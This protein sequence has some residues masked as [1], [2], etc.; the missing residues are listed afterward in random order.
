MGKD[1][2]L[3]PP[4][5]E[6]WDHLSRRLCLALQL[7]HT[8]GD[9]PCSSTEV[10]AGSVPALLA[11]GRVDCSRLRSAEDID[12][13]PALPRRF[14]P[15]TAAEVAAGTVGAIT[16]ADLRREAEPDAPV[17]PLD[18]E[19]QRRALVRYPVTQRAQVNGARLGI[20]DL[21]LP[22]GLLTVL[23]DNP[24]E[25]VVMGLLMTRRMGLPASIVQAAAGIAVA[26]IFDAEA[27]QRA[28]NHPL[29]SRMR[30]LVTG[31][32]A[33]NHISYRSVFAMMLHGPP[34]SATCHM[35]GGV[36]TGG[37]LHLLSSQRR[38]TPQE[39]V[40]SRPEPD[41]AALKRGSVSASARGSAAAAARPAGSGAAA[42]ASCSPAAACAVPAAAGA[43]AGASA[44]P[45]AP[46]STFCGDVA[47]A[48]SMRPRA[49]P[50]FVFWLPIAGQAEADAVSEGVDFDALYHFTILR[51]S[52][53][54]ALRETQA[55]MNQAALRDSRMCAVIPV[56]MLPAAVQAGL[57][58][59]YSLRD[60]SWRLLQETEAPLPC[61]AAFLQGLHAVG[62]AQ[63]AGAPLPAFEVMPA[64]LPLDHMSL[65]RL[66]TTQIVSG[67]ATRATGAGVSVG[68]ALGRTTA[69]FHPAASSPAWPADAAAALLAG[70]SQLT[71]ITRDSGRIQLR[72]GP[73]HWLLCRPSPAMPWLADRRPAAV[74]LSHH[75]AVA[76][77]QVDA[78]MLRT[79]SFGLYEQP[80]CAFLP[81]DAT[82]IVGI[83]EDAITRLLVQPQPPSPGQA[84]ATAAAAPAAAGPAAWVGEEA[85]EGYG[86][87]T[88]AYSAQLAQQQGQARRLLLSQ[89]PLAFSMLC[90]V[91]GVSHV[92]CNPLLAVSS[93]IPYLS[94]CLDGLLEA[95]TALYHA[96][97]SSG[98][99]L[100]RVLDHAVPDFLSLL[101]DRPMSG[102]WRTEMARAVVQE[103]A[104][105]RI[106][107]WSAPVSGLFPDRFAYGPHAG[108][109]LHM[110]VSS[111]LA[112]AAF[113]GRLSRGQLAF[114]RHPVTS[115]EL[116]WLLEHVLLPCFELVPEQTPEEDAA[117][118]AGGGAA[119][120]GAPVMGAG[121]VAAPTGGIAAS[122]AAAEQSS[123][124]AAA[125][126]VA[127]ADNLKA[128]RERM[129][130]ALK[131]A[132][133]AHD[134]LQQHVAAAVLLNQ[135]GDV[136]PAA[137]ASREH[138]LYWLGHDEA[139]A[140]LRACSD[141]CDDTMRV[142]YNRY[143]LAG[144]GTAT[145]LP[146]TKR[147]QRRLAVP[148]FAPVLR[149]IVGL[150]DLHLHAKAHPACA[151]SAAAMSSVLSPVP[152]AHQVTWL[153]LATRM[154]SGLQPHVEVL[155]VSGLPP[156][157][158]APA[159]A[160]MPAAATPAPL[161]TEALRSSIRCATTAPAASTAAAGAGGGRGGHAP[162]PTQAAPTQAAP[163]P[164]QHSLLRPNPPTVLA[165]EAAQQ[166]AGKQAFASERVFPWLVT[167]V[168]DQDSR[169]LAPYSNECPS[170]EAPPRLLTSKGAVLP[171]HVCTV[172]TCAHLAADPKGPRFASSYG[173]GDFTLL[174]SVI[175]PSAGCAAPAIA[176]AGALKGGGGVATAAHGRASPAPAA[177]SSASASTVAAAP[178]AGWVCCT[179][180]VYAEQAATLQFTTCPPL[181]GA[182]SPFL[183]LD[184]LPVPSH[185]L[186]PG[187]RARSAAKDA[188]PS[189]A[190][191]SATADEAAPDPL[192]MPAR[193]LPL[194][195]AVPANAGL[196]LSLLRRAIDGVGVGPCN[197]TPAD[198]LLPL[199]GTPGGAPGRVRIPLAGSA[200]AA[201]CRALASSVVA[202]A[203][204]GVTGGAAGAAAA[205]CPSGCPSPSCSPLASGAAPPS[206]A[207]AAAREAPGTSDTPHAV[208]GLPCGTS[209]THSGSALRSVLRAFC[210]PQEHAALAAPL[211]ALPLLLAGAGKAGGAAINDCMHAS[212]A[213]LLDLQAAAIAQQR[214]VMWEAVAGQAGLALAASAPPQQ[215]AVAPT[216]APPSGA[217]DGDDG[218]A[219]ASA[220]FKTG[221]LPPAATVS[222]LAASAAP[223]PPPAAA[224]PQHAA[225]AWPAP[226]PG[227]LFVN[228]VLLARFAACLCGV[229]E[230]EPARVRELNMALTNKAAG[231]PLFTSCAAGT[232]L[233]DAGVCP[234]RN[235]VGVLPTR[236]LAALRGMDLGLL[237][238]P[239]QVVFDR[240]GSVRPPHVMAALRTF[241]ATLAEADAAAEAARSA[242]PDG[243]EGGSSTRKAGDSGA[244]ARSGMG[245]DDGD[246]SGTAGSAS[247]D[248]DAVGEGAVEEAVLC[249]SDSPCSDDGSGSAGDASG[250]GSE[251][252]GRASGEES[253]ADEEVTEG[254]HGCAD[255]LPARAQRAPALPPDGDS[256]LSDSSSSGGSDGGGGDGGS[257]RVAAAGKASSA[258]PRG[259]RPG[260]ALPASVA[261]QSTASRFPTI[262]A[263]GSGD[264]NATAPAAALTRTAG[265]ASADALRLQ[266]TATH[267]AMAAHL[268]LSPQ[269]LQECLLAQ[270]EGGGGGRGARQP[271]AASLA[272]KGRIASNCR[273]LAKCKEVDSDEGEAGD[274]EYCAP[275][276]G[277]EG[278]GGA[279]G[280]DD[281]SEDEEAELAQCVDEG[282]L[283]AAVGEAEEGAEDEEEEAGAY[284]AGP[285]GSRRR[286][287]SR[288]SRGAEA[289]GGFSR[290]RAAPR[291]A[292]LAGAGAAAHG[293]AAAAAAAGAGGG[294][295]AAGGGS[296]ARTPHCTLC[297]ALFFGSWGEAQ[298]H[299]AELHAQLQQTGPQ[300]AAPGGPLPTRARDSY[301]CP[302]CGRRMRDSRDLGV[303]RTSHGTVA[304]AFV[305]DFLMPDGSACGYGTGK[306]Q[307]FDRHMR[308][309]TGERPYACSA[310]GCGASFKE[311]GDLKRHMDAH[312]GVRSHVCTTCGAAFT[313][314]GVLNRHIKAMHGG[315]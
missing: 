83:E 85:A 136:A 14:E 294:G 84:A 260:P 155:P 70:C 211:A 235:A 72:P 141:A 190:G 306:R 259:R 103:F 114:R 67:C 262:A 221:A 177:T 234:P 116:D 246:D 11:R 150:G 253:S 98:G 109:S 265:P 30:P 121:G 31:R 184:P 108:N 304:P 288:S 220:A 305:C 137:Q 297:P 167:C 162:A 46:P 248:E 289:A 93:L 207:A 64:E 59:A 276:E 213:T 138:A 17:P 278:G 101:L 73:M 81:P 286:S 269:E 215:G 206:T 202:A 224:A 212:S 200:T 57:R 303:H 261:P 309:H 170:A 62:A 130:P 230:R 311:A 148:A 145:R 219:A 239:E 161:P 63:Q 164:A 173:H 218:V 12:T 251:T 68:G 283:A 308:T 244:G 92:L 102:A 77:R 20:R 166:L 149:G 258:V 140:T 199:L 159:A 183:L 232:V 300:P 292:V 208:V 104:V 153:Q 113:V 9:I 125:A 245:A 267:I 35:L 26:G 51:T 272:A 157:A 143:G 223:A 291:G 112:S 37:A 39:Q 100:P 54:A 120:K 3:A 203:A 48:T 49:R 299:Q 86:E 236:D 18:T 174:P 296:A 96:P 231:V 169:Y 38:R 241:K 193:L 8:R 182:T 75:T 44:F 80:V 151:K 42:A 240:H 128:R 290:T 168:V 88:A 129:G 281:D 10:P 87:E 56:T 314:A 226:T 58:I 1:R 55:S 135:L 287:L 176:T 293:S 76:K 266:P 47:L 126:A 217:A 34:A 194:R 146:H 284:G 156:R 252:S 78:S 24:M 90:R 52:W 158:Q 312:A 301:D 25:T 178:A 198:L 280:S 152:A 165:A 279:G 36:E 205:A 107:R 27:A 263:E 179:S 16:A 216:A 210:T 53:L 105:A 21:L 123:C 29:R 5:A 209:V 43:K 233:L 131:A 214:Q 144:T 295:R 4:G 282:E 242:G 117:L 192:A 111:P 40:Q 175:R 229:T 50:W 133:A 28:H 204:G 74:A 19:E 2:V 45:A 115:Q 172:D 32:P 191:G 33:V 132:R 271:R 274:G 23:L 147:P 237:P 6:R 15:F 180:D 134:C 189:C 127:A 238:D 307:T 163:T 171:L 195:T 196:P 119:R 82:C 273:E 270:Q 264:A 94:R 99:S 222:A 187:R 227:A 310:P 302:D 110:T 69:L 257:A 22:G 298:A 249:G 181:T 186:P 275:G 124:A 250:S 188:R 61:T 79:F 142:Y 91:D 106:Q 255:P 41:S 13:L 228:P 160:A 71:S 122:G 243:G 254:P 65:P 139:A 60:D 256:S 118:R 154:R 95:A 277:E 89:P 315:S 313:R 225:A 66:S 201:V 197:R 285:R 185:M 247:D 7:L 97:V 268:G